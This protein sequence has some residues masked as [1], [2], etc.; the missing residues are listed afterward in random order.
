MIPFRPKERSESGRG[1]SFA[2][3]T[4]ADLPVALRTPFGAFSGGRFRP[5]A[6]KSDL[7][8]KFRTPIALKSDLLCDFAQG[9]ALSSNSIATTAWDRSFEQLNCNNGVGIA[10][11]SDP[12]AKFV[13]GSL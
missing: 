2:G 9:N 5:N 11:E 12:G 7:L 3:K 13:S 10:L 1:P 8:S 6:L 4:E